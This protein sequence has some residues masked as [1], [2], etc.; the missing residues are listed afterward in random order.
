MYDLMS[1]LTETWLKAEDVACFPCSSLK[2]HNTLKM[3]K[4]VKKNNHNCW[5]D[6]CNV[7]QL[8]ATVMQM[9][10]QDVSNPECGSSES[11]CCSIVSLGTL[12]TSP[13]VSVHTGVWSEWTSEWFFNALWLMQEEKCCS[14][15][16][17]LPFRSIL[18]SLSRH[19][20][21]AFS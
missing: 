4:L 6:Y 12:L 8:K 14:K 16:V 1:T 3:V 20:S 13:P 17:H 10:K 15:C 2:R 18:E 5:F 9:V 11:C 7:I 19:Y 21:S